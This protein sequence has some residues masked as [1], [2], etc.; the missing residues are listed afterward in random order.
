[1]IS[2]K[3][4]SAKELSIVSALDNNCQTNPAKQK[5]VHIA[6]CWGVREENPRT[7]LSSESSIGRYCGFQ[8]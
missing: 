3:H 1:M 2:V 5:I 7:I 8:I 6:E 4:S